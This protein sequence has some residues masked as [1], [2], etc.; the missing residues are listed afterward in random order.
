MA[1]L[2]TAHF[3]TRLRPLR[4]NLLNGLYNRKKRSM[5]KILSLEK[6]ILSLDIQTQRINARIQKLDFT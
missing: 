3:T 5:K 4:D 2:R 1:I 6:I